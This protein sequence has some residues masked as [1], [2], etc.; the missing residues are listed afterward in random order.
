MATVTASPIKFYCL[1]ADLAH[2]VHDLGSDEL[3]FI[4][5]D[6]APLLTSTVVGDIAQIS[7]GGGYPAGGIA[8]NVLSSGQTGG[9]Y[10]LM[11]EDYIFTATGPVESFRYIVLYNNTS[12][13]KALILYLDYGSSIAT[14][15]NNRQLLID[16][17]G[18]DGA[19]IL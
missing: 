6:T 18:V 2:G 15:T 8:I 3:K 12:S 16:F 11:L 13:S 10:R 4:L 9:I 7:A 19:V 14:M 1:T 17:N 5:T